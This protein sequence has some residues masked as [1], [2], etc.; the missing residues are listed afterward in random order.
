MLHIVD[1]NG[2]SADKRPFSI[3][4]SPNS[5]TIEFCIK[6][7]PEGR[8]TQK[9]DKLDV[10]D[11]LGIEG[12]L[13]TFYYNHERSAVFIAG[14]TGIAPFIS[15][16]RYIKE[17]RIMGDFVLFYSVRTQKHILYKRELEQLAKATNIKIIITITREESTKWNGEHGR[18]EEQMLKKYLA[19]PK[20]YRFYICGPVNMTSSL[21]NLLVSI[22]I[23]E[24]NILFEGW[25]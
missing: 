21:H 15:M 14:G 7:L 1:Q 16:L 10:G 3:A 17:N 22:G 6:I 18:V 20:D 2:Q 13:G 8:F 23:K 24:E 12:P 25:G 4:S 5:S 9:L 11:T 19:N